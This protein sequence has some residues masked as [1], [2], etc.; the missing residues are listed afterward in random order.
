MI[1]HVRERVSANN[2]IL[3]NSIAIAFV[4][5]ISVIGMVYSYTD[6]IQFNQHPITH[7]VLDFVCYFLVLPLG[8]RIHGRYFG[9]SIQQLH[10]GKFAT[11]LLF[12]HVQLK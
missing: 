8:F 7:T 9:C 4:I 3:V 2:E 6:C 10:S 5:Y 11:Y 12:I 1:G